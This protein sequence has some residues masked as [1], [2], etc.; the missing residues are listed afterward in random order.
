MSSDD[1]RVRVWRPCG[2]RLNPA[3]DLQR[4]T[5]PTADVMVWGAIAYNTRSPLA[6]IRDTMTAQR[7]LAFHQRKSPQKRQNQKNRTN[8][9]RQESAF[10]G[11][12]WWVV[13]SHLPGAPTSLGRN[14][15]RGPLRLSKDPG[16]S[17]KRGQGSTD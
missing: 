16:K 12:A 11:R 2:E 15:R 4:H 7:D 3:F 1:N 9:L 17:D 13:T 5:T 10:H 8:N 14:R 6:L